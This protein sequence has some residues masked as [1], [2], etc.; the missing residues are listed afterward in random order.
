MR[1]LS[2]LLGLTLAASLALVPASA[3]SQEEFSASFKNTEIAEF[4]QS[5]SRNLEETII[6]DPEVRGRINV[7]SYNVMNR[8]QY[9]A[10]FLNVLEVY[11]FAVVRMDNGV[12]KVIRERDARTKPTPVVDDDSYTGDEWVT[13]VIAVQNVSVRELGPLLRQLNEQAKG[14]AVMT[15]DPSNVIMLSGRAELLNRL[16][17]IIRRVDQAGNQDVEVVQLQHSSAAEMVRIAQA[18]F[19]QQ[20]SNVPE[21]LVPRIVPDERTNRVLISGEP[22]ARERAIRLIK[23]LDTEMQTSGNTRV[24]YL[25][26][27]KANEMVDL[28]RGM[29]QSILAEQRAQSSGGGQGGQAAP[30]GRAGGEISIEAHEPTNALVIT[31]QPDMLRA[32]EGVINQLDIRRAQVL[33][34]AIIVEVFEGDGINFGIQWVSEDIGMMQHSNGQMVPIGQ[35]GVA[36]EAARTQPGAVTERVDNAGNIF[37]T[38]EPDRRGDYTML[39]SLLGNAN[40]LL[41][42]TV[43][44]GWAAVIQAVATTTNSNILSAPSITTLDNQEASILVGQEVPTLTGST[45]SSGNDNPF[46]TI[47][48]REI[49]V[50]LRVTPQINEGDAVQLLIEQEVSSIAG[51]TAVDVTFNKREL[52]TTVLA[53]DGETIVLGGLIDEDVQESLSKVPLL[54]DIPIIGHLF[55]STSVTTRKRNLMVFIRPTII[56]DDDRMGNL[57]QRKYSYI[58]AQQIE[59]R[60]RGVSLRSRDTVPVLPEWDDDAELPPE[61][62]RFLDEWRRDIEELEREAREGQGGNR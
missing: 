24:Y 4:I 10:F 51:S 41:M 42:G 48:R 22:R 61:Y 53:R 8:D 38:R 21:M 35:L 15:Y 58:R 57:S 25:R 52:R 43:Q 30:R 27:A 36:A 40:G 47:D 59:Q 12:L 26:Y 29:T 62:Q 7:R 50:R 49:G 23:Q 44:D 1:L 54:G 17:E 2:Q 14:G 37:T 60:Q 13:R 18:V 39:A 6:I 3:V 16:V 20:G 31:A 9:Y 55:K 46:Q 32:L 33:V 11:G 5:V 56:R 34:E 28:L 45:P 19:Q